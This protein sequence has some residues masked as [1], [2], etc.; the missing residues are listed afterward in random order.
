[1]FGDH[2]NYSRVTRSFKRK[3]GGGRRKGRREEGRQK[4]YPVKI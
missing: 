4:L 2:L 1:M 3:E